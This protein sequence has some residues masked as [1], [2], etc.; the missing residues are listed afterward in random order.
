VLNIMIG[1]KDTLLVKTVQ[2]D[3]SFLGNLDINQKSTQRCNYVICNE[4]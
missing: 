3:L 2:T 4:Y 1:A